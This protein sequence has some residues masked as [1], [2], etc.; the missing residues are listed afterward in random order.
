MDRSVNRA[1]LTALTLAGVA[2]TGSA[3]FA[4][5]VATHD[6]QAT[7]AVQ[8]QLVSGLSA[9]TQAR[10]T[11]YQVSGVGSVTL[12]STN[13]SITVAGTSVASGW[14]VAG[15][16]GAGSDVQV[17]FTDGRTIV[18]FHASLQ[19]GGIAVA[20]SSTPVPGT[21]N[22]TAAPPPVS[23]VV[24]TPAT[25]AAPPTTHQ[26]QSPPVTTARPAAGTH[27]THKPVTTTAPSSAHGGEEPGDD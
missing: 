25:P 12:A 1:W 8:P 14:T 6:A 11:T 18:T 4:G 3:A 15:A 24:A 20:L 19:T 9:T 5:S 17:R 10:H 16:S 2:G 22:T 21:T 13:G 26:R 23:V 7:P 27:S